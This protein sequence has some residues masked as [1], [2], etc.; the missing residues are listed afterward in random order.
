MSPKV[1]EEEFVVV[2]SKLKLAFVVPV[3]VYVEG[4]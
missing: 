3:V 2:L 4:T 1:I